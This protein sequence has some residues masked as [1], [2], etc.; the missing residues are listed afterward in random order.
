M[1]YMSS[2]LMQ[3]VTT[4]YLESRLKIV[5][6]H[7][8]VYAVHPGVIK[9]DLYEHVAIARVFG[10]ILKLLYKVNFRIIRRA[11]HRVEQEQQK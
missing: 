8:K 10:F 2:K 9:T 4:R 11:F 6:D 5:G 1:A 7:V 3:V